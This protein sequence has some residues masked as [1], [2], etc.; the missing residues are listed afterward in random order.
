MQR[1]LKILHCPDLAGGHPYGLARAERAIGLSSHCVALRPHPFGY[2]ADQFLCSGGEI[3]SQVA[4]WRLL[5]MALRTYDV[6]HFN[7]GQ[8]TMPQRVASDTTNRNRYPS[9]VKLLYNLYA[10]VFELKDLRLLK[11][12]GKS[13]IMTYQGDDARQGGFLRSHYA[14]SPVDEPC[15]YTRE[16]DRLKQERIRAVDCYADAIFAVNPDL[17]HVLPSRAKFLPYAH[18]DVGSIRPAP[19]KW[20]PTP[21]VIHAPS[22]RGLKGT[23][24]VLNAVHRLR[25]EGIAL[26][27]VLIENLSHSEAMR[28]YE[29]ADLLVDQLLYGWYGGL[30]VELMALGKPVVAYIREEDLD[31]VPSAMRTELTVVNATPESIYRVLRELVT[32]RRYELTEL[33]LRGRK[34]VENWHDPIRVASMLKGTYESIFELNRART[35]P[36]H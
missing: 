12:M 34:Y 2:Q 1:P 18:L 26:K 8:S 10:G 11:R 20:N 28:L 14:I 33:G 24:H 27:F 7:F 4:R 25:S 15:Y 29:E 32:V 23:K 30:A 16:S 9:W 19:P 31:F 5:A 6:V 35:V 22:H 21:V 17:L 3:A 36:H 13:V